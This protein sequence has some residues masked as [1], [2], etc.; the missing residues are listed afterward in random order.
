[1]YRM[2]YISRD[3]EAD[4][5]QALAFIELARLRLDALD[6]RDRKLAWGSRFHGGD[7]RRAW[8]SRLHGSDRKLAWGSRFHGSDRKLAW[9]SRFHGRD[10]RRAWGSR[11]LRGELLLA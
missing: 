9:G 5:E 1:M 3:S 8:G 7:R 2:R 6:G 10:R 11:F 4:E